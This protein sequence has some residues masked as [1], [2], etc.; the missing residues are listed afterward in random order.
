L[1]GTLLN[2]DRFNT[3]HPVATVGRNDP[4]FEL[5]MWRGPAWNN[6][7]FWAALGCLQ[8]GRRDGARQLLERALDRVAAEFARTGT[9]W[10]FY[11]PLGGRPEEL[12]RKPGQAFTMPCREYY[13]HNPLWAMARLWSALA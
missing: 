8:Y 1:D 13:G 10:E 9:V 6:M 2:P 5:R 11:H 4:A 12:G 3:P 7:T